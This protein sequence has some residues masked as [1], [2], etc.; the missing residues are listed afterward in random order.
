MLENRE[1]VLGKSE[2]YGETVG[3]CVEGEMHHV[4]QECTKGE[5]LETKSFLTSKSSS[6]HY[7]RFKESKAQKCFGILE[8]LNEYGIFPDIEIQDD[9][10]DE[11]MMWEKIEAEIK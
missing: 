3:T 9:K 4:D 6:L 8:L 1:G 7:S 11:I 10:F 5:H 2:F